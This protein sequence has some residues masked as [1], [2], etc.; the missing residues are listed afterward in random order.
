MLAAG[1]ALAVSLVLIG[2]IRFAP[3]LTARFLA[4][5]LPVRV[6]VAVALVAPLGLALG[7]PFPAGLRWLSAERAGGLQAFEWLP[8]ASGRRSVAWVWGVNGL[9]SVLG[10]AGAVAVAMVGGFS[11]SLLLGSLIYLGIFAGAALYDGRVTDAG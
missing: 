6:V 8:V 3:W 5:V 4:A 9:A 2:Y 10:S 1:A 7:V 11:W